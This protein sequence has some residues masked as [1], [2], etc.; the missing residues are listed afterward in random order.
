MLSQLASFFSR[1]FHK[2]FACSLAFFLPTLHSLT[3]DTVAN[4]NHLDALDQVDQH[5]THGSYEYATLTYSGPTEL[6]GEDILKKTTL[7]Q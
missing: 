7:F 4:A 6:N 2:N 1:A 3:L 5:D